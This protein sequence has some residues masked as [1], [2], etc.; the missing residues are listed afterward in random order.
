MKQDT[1]TF[2]FAW[3][4]LRALLLSELRT[5]AVVPDAHRLSS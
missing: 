2:F 4:D 3:R 5:G 1:T